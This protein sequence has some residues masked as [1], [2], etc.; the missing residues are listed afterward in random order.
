MKKILFATHNQNKA[1][2]ISRQC[3]GKIEI[4]T[5]SELGITDEIHET[6]STLEGNALLKARFLFNKFHLPCFA[7]DTGLEVDALNGA[8]GVFSARYS[9]QDGDS[10]RNMEKLLANLKYSANRNARFRT[11]VAF[12][13]SDG[14]EHLF[15]GIVNGTIATEKHGDSGFGYDPIFLPQDA[16]GLT[17]AQMSID[18]KNKISHRARAITKFVQFIESK[19]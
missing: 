15:E 4:V 1:A 10:E 3:N 13:D 18:A 9:G 14:N 12:I 16:D 11:V 5:L 8:P 6:A 19:Q 17:F 7:D 2:E